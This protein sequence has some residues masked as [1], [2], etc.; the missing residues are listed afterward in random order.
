M[1]IFTSI[2]SEEEQK[3]YAIPEQSMFKI[4]DTFIQCDQQYHKWQ[5]Q[6]QIFNDLDEKYSNYANQSKLVER[7]RLKFL[8]QNNFKNCNAPKQQWKGFES[9]I[10]ML[11]YGE[12][13]DKYL[14]QWPAPQ[15]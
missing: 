8:Y 2:P 4:V 14:E 3:K 12:D 9:N 11:V 10:E 15:N 7:S 1:A 6:D 5:Y 13:T